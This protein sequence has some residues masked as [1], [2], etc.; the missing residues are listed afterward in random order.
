MPIAINKLVPWP[1]SILMPVRNEADVIEMVIDEWVN[2]V[3]RYLPDGSEIL[4]D[5][6]AST[7]GTRQILECRCQKYPFLHVRFNERPDG[8]L[9]AA[10][11]LYIHGV[12]AQFLKTPCIICMGTSCAYA[13]DQELV[14]ENYL[15][16]T[17]IDSLFTYAMTKR[18]LYVGF[19]A[20]QKQYGLQ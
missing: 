17:P 6:A 1:V 10:R 12:Y 4:L 7:D 9:A 8:F 16:G 18:M 14:E 5:D 2:D 13:P 15:V 20:L 3:F 11:R 19:L